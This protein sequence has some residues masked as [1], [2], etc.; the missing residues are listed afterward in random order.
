MGVK[1][2]SSEFLKYLD[3]YKIA[4][5][6]QIKVI[7]KEAY[8]ESM[9]VKINDIQKTISKEVAQNLFVQTN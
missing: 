2:S 3:K 1:D 8:D 9:T 6:S 7:S 5:G 4:L